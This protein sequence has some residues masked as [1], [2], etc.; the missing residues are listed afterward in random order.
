MATYLFGQLFFTELVKS[1]ELLGQQNILQET[2]C[3]QLDSHDNLK[4][5]KY[6]VSIYH[7]MNKRIPKYL[8]AILYYSTIL[9]CKHYLIINEM[10]IKDRHVKETKKIAFASTVCFA[11]CRLFVRR[12]KWR[13]STPAYDLLLPTTLSDR[14]LGI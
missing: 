13:L 7:I 1:V 2:T 3:S 6:E 8:F 10:K 4:T 11:W 5:Q 12:V 9:N 14:P